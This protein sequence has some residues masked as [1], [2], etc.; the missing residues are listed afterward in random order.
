MKK[1]VILLTA[2]TL[3]TGTAVFVS[4]NEKT[5]A[6]EATFNTTDF[7]LQ[8]IKHGEYLVTAMGCDDCHSPKVMGPHGP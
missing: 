2:I 8:Q 6:K 7:T 5:D 4:C 1:I 3:V